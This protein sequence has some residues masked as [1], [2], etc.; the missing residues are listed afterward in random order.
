MPIRTKRG[1]KQQSE[2][3]FWNSPIEN[4]LW[5]M[6]VFQ[7]RL[8]PWR[9]GLVGFCSLAFVLAR[10]RI[11]VALGLPSVLQQLIHGPSAPQQLKHGAAIVFLYNF[12]TPVH[13]G[14]RFP[15]IRHA[16][17]RRF[18]QYG[19]FDRIIATTIQG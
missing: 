15:F 4:I 12:L 6:F 7:F 2:Y 3:C 16:S 5:L 14:Q 11:P 8:F 19:P 9:L 1:Y 17:L 10:I 18:P 13:A